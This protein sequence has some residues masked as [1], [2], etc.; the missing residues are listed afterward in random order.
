MPNIDKIT[1]E[2]AM[3]ELRAAAD[4]I[5]DKYGLVVENV[6]GKYGSTIELKVK[7]AKADIGENGV[8]MASAAAMAFKANARYLGVDPDA[9][10]K[11]F[12][13]NGVEFVFTGYLDRGQKFRY[14]AKRVSDGSSFKFTEA[15]IKHAFPAPVS[16]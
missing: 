9:L 13:S 15:T 2:M 12:V 11:T 14:S 6:S 10:G 8:N 5:F 4:L 1:C 7:G 16:V 3:A